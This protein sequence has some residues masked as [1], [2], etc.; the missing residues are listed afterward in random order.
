MKRS[1]KVETRRAS[2]WVVAGVV[3]GLAVVTTV[4]APM[5]A[6]EPVP[7]EMAVNAAPVSVET[8]EI[9]PTVVKTGD[10][11]IQTYRVRFP[12]LINEGREVIILED[13]MAP[14]NLPCIRLRR[15]L[16]T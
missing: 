12:D 10:L 4:T 11:I 8:L 13:R 15:Y 2:A 7:D 5:F 3:S 9:E 6:Q 16:S 14:E 1:S